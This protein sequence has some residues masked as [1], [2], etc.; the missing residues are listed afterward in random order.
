MLLRSQAENQ[1]M[2]AG[3][4]NIEVMGDLDKDSLWSRVVKAWLRRDCR[5]AGGVNICKQVFQ[6]V[7]LFKQEK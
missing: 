5:K 2:A 1:E 4:G 6:E 3:F 7:L